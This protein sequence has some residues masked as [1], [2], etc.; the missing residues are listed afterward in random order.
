MGVAFF[1]FLSSN[2]L[3]FRKK[4]IGNTAQFVCGDC[5][6]IYVPVFG[7][8]GLILCTHYDGSFFVGFHVENL[9]Y[10]LYC[11]VFSVKTDKEIS[12]RT[13]RTG[14]TVLPLRNRRKTGGFWGLFKK[15]DF[16]TAPQ[17]RRTGFRRICARISVFAAFQ[18]DFC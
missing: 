3:I 5:R 16:L 13:A 17:I 8:H 4:S 1:S 10:L 12:R 15:S 7:K 9:Q 2:V 6:V 14:Q 18:L 11:C